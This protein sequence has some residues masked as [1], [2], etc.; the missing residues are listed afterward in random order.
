MMLPIYHSVLVFGFLLSI[1]DSCNKLETD[2][3][4]MSVL[5]KQRDCNWRNCEING[6]ALACKD[7]EQACDM[8]RNQCVAVCKSGD[9]CN[10][11]VCPKG[12]VCVPGLGRC[13]IQAGMGCY[14]MGMDWWTERDVDISIKPCLEKPSQVTFLIINQQATSLYFKSVYG[15][16]IQMNLWVKQCNNKQRLR[17]GE[18]NFCPTPCPEQGPIEEFDCGRPPEIATVIPAGKSMNMFWSGQEEVGLWRSCNKQRPK[19]CVTPKTTMPGTY[20]IEICA[21]PQLQSGRADPS[22]PNQWL[23]GILNGDTICKEVQFEY[24]SLEAVKIIF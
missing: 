13:G 7:K 6:G 22:V 23:D 21:Y 12:T 4:R 16:S 20:V 8:Y 2:S 10:G 14:D 15:K 5:M 11:V 19:Y 24:P 17:L 18:N 1:A 3:Q 9:C